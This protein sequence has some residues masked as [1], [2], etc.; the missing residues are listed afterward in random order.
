MAASSSSETRLNTP[1]WL[2]NRTTLPG[3]S[4]T[5]F[6]TRRPSTNVPFVLPRSSTLQPPEAPAIRRWA[7]D[8][9]PSECNITICVLVPDA[10]DRHPAA[11][12]RLVATPDRHRSVE[13]NYAR[14]LRKVRSDQQH[15][16]SGGPAT[17]CRR[18][19]DRAGA[20]VVA[21]AHVH[22]RESVSN[23]RAKRQSDAITS[24]IAITSDSLAR[25]APPAEI[26][27]V[28]VTYAPLERAIARHGT[29]PS[30]CASAHRRR[31]GGP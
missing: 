30:A 17:D 27:D 20:A 4:A 28:P 5:G 14:C 29:L 13:A 1:A 3:D 11:A 19:P 10:G 15:G 21:H 8:S 9:V 12:G 18:L 31:R 25:Q 24:F 22:A 7:R 26:S 23:S 6:V 2:P 16:R